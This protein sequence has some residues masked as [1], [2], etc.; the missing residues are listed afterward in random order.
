MNE[1]F[2]KRL[3]RY[4]FISTVSQTAKDLSSLDCNICLDHVNSPYTILPCGHIFCSE[5]ISVYLKM[6]H[7]QRCP[8]C[9]EC[10]R[11][12]EVCWIE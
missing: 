4:N 11:L 8:V 10:Y 7:I 9:K 6:S 3:S 1:W 2:R 5:C 12:S